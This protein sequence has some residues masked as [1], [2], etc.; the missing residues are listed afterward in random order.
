MKMVPKDVR[1]QTI[2]PAAIPCCDQPQKEPQ[3]G[4]FNALELLDYTIKALEERIHHHIASISPILKAE[5]PERDSNAK[6]NPIYDRC[7]IHQR[8]A[9]STEYLC[10]LTETINDASYRL[11][12]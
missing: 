7:T 6:P 11:D 10:G 8:I 2:S 3:D 9:Q 4:V 5:T 1:N 12:L